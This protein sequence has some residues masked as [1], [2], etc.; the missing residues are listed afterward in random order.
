[1]LVLVMQEE[2]K[3][4]SVCLVVLLAIASGFVSMACAAVKII[5]KIDLKWCEGEVC[6][7]YVR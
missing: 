1:M 6:S 4:T 2:W 3:L 7:K 5:E